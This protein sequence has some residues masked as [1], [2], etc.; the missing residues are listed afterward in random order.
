MRNKLAP[1]RSLRASESTWRQLRMLALTRNET[2]DKTLVFLLEQYEGFY[3]KEKG[4]GTTRPAK[5]KR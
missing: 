4:I 2:I 1:P 5:P 3:A